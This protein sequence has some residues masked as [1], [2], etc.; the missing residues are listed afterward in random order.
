MHRGFFLADLYPEKNVM[1]IKNFE[2]PQ[3]AKGKRK[4]QKR[5][6]KKKKKRKKEKK[7]TEGWKRRHRKT[8]PK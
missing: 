3:K 1:I 2:F 4:K 6:I 5:E 7:N 8:K